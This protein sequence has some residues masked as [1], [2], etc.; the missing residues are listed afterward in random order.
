MKNKY[1]EIATFLL[2]TATVV[3]GFLSTVDAALFPPEWRPYLPLVI[4]TIIA[5]KQLAY[6][7]LDWLDD[8]EFN[9]SYKAPTTLLKALGLLLCL[10]CLCSC[11]SLTPDRTRALADVG[12][13]ILESRGHV[14]PQDAADIRLLGNTVLPLRAP[15]AVTLS[16]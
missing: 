11:Q 2:M 3:F 7:F 6:G 9:K 15:V 5:L 4:G 14:A 12:L 8:G 1:I 13:A 16:K 10:S